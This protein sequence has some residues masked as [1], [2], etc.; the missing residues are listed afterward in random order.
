MEV[1]GNSPADVLTFSGTTREVMLPLYPTTA[2]CLSL[3]SDDVTWYFRPLFQNSYPTTNLV[4]RTS[5]LAVPVNLYPARY[6][7]IALRAVVPS[8]S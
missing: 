3:A 4:S 1:T 7:G 2:S 6:S 8:A 5:L